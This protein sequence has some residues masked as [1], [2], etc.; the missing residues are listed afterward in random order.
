MQPCCGR[1][2]K[3][4][5]VFSRDICNEEWP[6]ASVV[7]SG[8]ELAQGTGHRI[9]RVDRVIAVP[10]SSLTLSTVGPRFLGYQRF[11]RSG[12]RVAESL[13]HVTGRRIS[14]K[15]LLSV[16]HVTQVVLV[17]VHIVAIIRMNLTLTPLRMNLLY[18]G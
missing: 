13:K 8:A 16:S 17:L 2:S 4:K 3:S 7:D 15:I 18:P 11:V 5:R 9:Q 6:R 12:V 14:C 1:I 10:L